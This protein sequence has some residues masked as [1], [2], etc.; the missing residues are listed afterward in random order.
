MPN[1]RIPAQ[2]VFKI[3]C[4]HGFS[5][6][7]M[8]DSKKGHN[9]AIQGLAKKTRLI[10]FVQTLLINFQS[11]TQIGFLDIVGT[12]FSQKG[13]NSGNTDALRLKLISTSS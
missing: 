5:S 9:F 10:I 4:Q 2:A 3:L 8:A 7:I 13:N 11:Y 6:A 1:I 12:L